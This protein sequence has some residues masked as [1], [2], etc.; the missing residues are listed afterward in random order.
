PYRR[1][2]T[3]FKNLDEAQRAAL[4]RKDPRYGRIV[5]R[6]EHV[7]EGEIIEALHR[8]VPART[9]DAV[10]RRTRAGMGRCQGGFCMPR[11]SLLMARELGIPL[12]KLTKSGPGSPLFSRRTKE[13]SPQKK[14]WWIDD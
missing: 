13:P 7:T 6:C 4:I 10:K 11:V 3:H 14:E 2:I 9:L 12:E 5:C 8:P 1:D